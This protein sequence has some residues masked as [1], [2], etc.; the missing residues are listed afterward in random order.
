MLCYAG[1][2]QSQA[3]GRAAP[4]R[5]GD[6]GRPV[7]PK[8]LMMPVNNKEK[9]FLIDGNPYA[10]RA[11][12]G[13]KSLATSGGQPT[14][15][16]YGFTVMLM[17]LLREEKPDYLAVAFDLVA[18]TFRH[19]EFAEYKAQRPKM[20]EDL[21]KQMP[22]IKEVVSAFNIPIFELEGYE[23]D[24][25]LA[26]IAKKTEEEDKE[27]FIL[28][29]DKDVL[30]LVNA[31]IR[32]SS[33]HRGGLTY[34][35][36]EV[37]E[38]YGV[39]PEQM[40]DVLA[41]WGDASDNIPGVSGIGRKTA[42]KLIQKFGN[43]ENLL[44]NPAQV[45]NQRQRENLMRCAET[46][47]LSKRLVTVDKNVPISFDLGWCRVEKADRIRLA[48]LFRKLEFKKLVREFESI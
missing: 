44:R 34:D 40:T 33:P 46:A 27:I 10:Y 23:A 4:A 8:V 22:L 6:L 16:V 13:L 29:S 18:P 30:Q 5:R 3:C 1:I 11:F 20:P 35:V 15:A 38:R 25:I 14:N 24:D 28:T 45:S 42:V 48:E 47:K 2:L 12:Y 19:R 21:Q 9:L 43:L 17:K 26:T 36:N 37:R 32:V 31:N 7:L 39:E 41:L